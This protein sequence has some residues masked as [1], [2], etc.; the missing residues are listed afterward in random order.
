MAGIVKYLNIGRLQIRFVFRHRWEKFEDKT[1]KIMNDITMWREWELGFFF[2]R[3]QI[4]GKKNF[5]KPKEWGKN[6]VYE[7]MFGINLLICKFWFTFVRGGMH[8]KIDA[9]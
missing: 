9:Q 7:Y 1:E 3:F 2:R 4:V 8:I 5:H 6:L